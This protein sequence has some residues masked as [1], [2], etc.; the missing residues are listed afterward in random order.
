M[1]WYSPDELLHGAGVTFAET[2]AA[3]V[4]GGLLTGG[5]TLLG[6]WFTAR[7]AAET[8]AAADARRDTAEQLR[9]T[10]DHKFAA[11]SGY[12]AKLDTWR[13]P[14]TPEVLAGVERA[15]AAYNHVKF[16]ASPDVDAAASALINRSMDLF[17]R[18]AQRPLDSDAVLAS[19]RSY[20]EAYRALLQTMRRELG[21]ES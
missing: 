20:G 7:K 4:V 21:I 2:L 12:I 1:A 9:W 11:Y 8:A 3:V 16:L 14:I 19:T 15:V 18:F 10:R 6:V 13:E 17:A 5:L